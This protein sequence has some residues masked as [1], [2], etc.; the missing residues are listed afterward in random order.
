[1]KVSL[2]AHQ[3]STFDFGPGRPRF[4]IHKVAVSALSWFFM[5]RS[6]FF[7]RMTVYRYV[8]YWCIVNPRRARVM[9][10]VLFLCLSV[11]LSV[12]YH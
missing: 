6:S 7:S 8:H 4:D 10:V 3:S 2:T 11:C 9:V 1:M 12:C 5:D